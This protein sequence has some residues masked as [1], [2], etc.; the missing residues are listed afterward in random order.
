MGN[1]FNLEAVMAFAEK[2]HL[3]VVEDNCDAVGSLYNQGFIPR[4]VPVYLIKKIGQIY[5]IML[6]SEASQ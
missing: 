2:H 1:R 3:W 5:I 4:K 6:G